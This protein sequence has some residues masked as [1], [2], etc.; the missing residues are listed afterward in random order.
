MAMWLSSVVTA[1]P[2]CILVIP[3]LAAQEVWGQ[4]Q[5]GSVT[6][7]FVHIREVFYQ[8]LFQVLS[9]QVDLSTFYKLN[10]FLLKDLILKNIFERENNPNKNIK[11]YTVS[12]PNLKFLESNLSAKVIWSRGKRSGTIVVFILINIDSQEYLIIKTP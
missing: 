6:P 9:R 12:N 2:A 5:G 4:E 8:Y 3:C 1:H 11:N 10:N 7:L